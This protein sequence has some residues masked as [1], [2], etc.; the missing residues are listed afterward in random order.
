M[1]ALFFGL[2]AVGHFKF[3]FSTL[4]VHSIYAQNL[5]EELRDRYP[6]RESLQ[7]S[8]DLL[9]NWS[10]SYTAYVTAMLDNG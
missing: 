7:I 5:W 6:E 10:R 4:A 3:R 2:S 8:N 1:L 9:R